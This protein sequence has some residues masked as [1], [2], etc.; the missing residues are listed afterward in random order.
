MAKPAKVVA[1]KSGLTLRSVD[2]K[3]VRL[4]IDSAEALRSRDIIDL[5]RKLLPLDYELPKYDVEGEI[6][7]KVTVKKKKQ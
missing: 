4:K 3:Q 7:V 1:V 2:G 6:E 5:D